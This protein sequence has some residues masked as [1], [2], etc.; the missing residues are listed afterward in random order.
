MTCRQIPLFF[1]FKIFMSNIGTPI[2]IH[3]NGTAFWGA[4][5]A[6]M[7][8]IAIKWKSILKEARWQ[9]DF[10]E[11]MIGITTTL[12]KYLEKLLSTKYH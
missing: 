6:I 1:A 5:R 11:R 12:K 8:E 4:Q 9:R 7:Q 3:F 10:L 2:L